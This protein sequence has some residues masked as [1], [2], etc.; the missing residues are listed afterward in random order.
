[1]NALNIL[2][3]SASRKVSLIKS[4]QQALKEEKL[5]GFIVAADSSPDS[6]SMKFADISTLVPS[7][8]NNGTDYEFFK[9]IAEICIQSGIGLIVPTRD[10]ELPF[11]AEHKDF[12]SE[13]GIFVAIPDSECVGLCQDKLAF[14]DFCISNNFS[15]PQKIDDVTRLPV[16][17]KARYGHGGNSAQRADTLPELFAIKR[18]FGESIVQENI[19][20]PEYTI[21]VFSD[22]NSKVLS[23]VP[24]QRIKIMGG[25]SWVSTTTKNPDIMRESQRLA[26]TLKLKYHSVIQC[27]YD[28]GVVKFI[29]V[30]PRF[31]GASNCSFEAGANSP[32][33][34][35]QLA[36]G[37]QVTAPH[38]GDFVDK[39][40]M[41]TYS[42]D[43][44]VY[45]EMGYETKTERRV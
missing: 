39:L 26:E 29:E 32:R 15:V 1:M 43:T 42:C 31:G 9:S 24:R 44:F 2:I 41:L 4:F 14:Y 45:P 13:Q 35:V 30:N 7:L 23:V 3:T 17:I 40:T 37:R 25:E 20:A 36:T 18:R 11:F 6:A 21:D 12:F 34:L 8:P 10:G 27:F 16:F 33:W 28:N 19:S 22:S 38:I 5:G